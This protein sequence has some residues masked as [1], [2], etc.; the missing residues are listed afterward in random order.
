MLTLLSA[1][2]MCQGCQIVKKA[3]QDANVAF[4]ERDIRSL[5]ERE[6]IAVVADLRCCGWTEKLIIGANGQPILEGP[7]VVNET[8]ALWAGFL[9]PDGKTVR[10]EFLD[11][12]YHSKAPRR[13]APFKGREELGTLPSETF[14]IYEYIHCL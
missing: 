5:T 12:L 10:Q 7:I 2:K 8:G 13:P 14:I 11:V 6:I 9:L 4:Q 3:I 1:G